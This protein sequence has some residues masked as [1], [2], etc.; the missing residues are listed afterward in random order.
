MNYAEEKY[1]HRKLKFE[2]IKKLEASLNY[3]KFAYLYKWFDLFR[4]PYK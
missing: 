2:L 1:N 3:K 4:T